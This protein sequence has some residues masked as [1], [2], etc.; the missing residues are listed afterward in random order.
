M[1]V[2]HDQFFILDFNV[3]TR[4]YSM[5]LYVHGL[6]RF[7]PV[8]NEPVGSEAV[9]AHVPLLGKP[10]VEVAKQLPKREPTSVRV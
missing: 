8:T 10:A 9:L 3:D 4:T 6:R 7:K 5:I 1:A 2:I